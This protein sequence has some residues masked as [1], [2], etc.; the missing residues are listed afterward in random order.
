M[1]DVLEELSN[2]QV[3]VGVDPLDASEK[4]KGN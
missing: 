3:L 2:L 4:E 1:D